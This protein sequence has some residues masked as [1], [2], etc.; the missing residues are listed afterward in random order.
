MDGRKDVCIEGRKQAGKEVGEREG[1]RI[2]G[3]S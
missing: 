2:R 3:N 1:K